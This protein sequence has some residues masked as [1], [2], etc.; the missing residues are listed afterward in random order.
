MSD[1]KTMRIDFKIAVSQRGTVLI[2]ALIVLV[3]MAISA[4][5]LTR[6]VD[7]ANLVAGNLAF[8]QGALHATERGM[9]LA[10]A[11]FDSFTIPP[12]ALSSMSATETNNSTNGYSATLLATDSRGVPTVLLNTTT[13]DTTYPNAKASLT[14]TGETVRYVIDRQCTRTGTAGT[15]WCTLTNINPPQVQL[16]AKAP[17]YTQAPL[18]RVTVRVDGP[19]NTVS[20]AQAIFHS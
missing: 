2:V 19:R 4:V 8:K 3:A 15:A 16:G 12:G 13:F 9:A 5:A 20:F 1:K 18:F 14:D 17:E 10:L 11:K 6:S 7:T